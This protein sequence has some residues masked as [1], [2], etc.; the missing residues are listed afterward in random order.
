MRDEEKGMKKNIKN[1]IKTACSIQ[2]TPSLELDKSSVTVRGACLA[3]R[4]GDGTGERFSYAVLQPV[5]G[6]GG[7]DVF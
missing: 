3:R 6:G 5:G 7:G 1:K 4:R 2:L